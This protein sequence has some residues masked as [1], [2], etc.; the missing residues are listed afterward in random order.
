MFAATTTATTTHGDVDVADKPAIEAAVP[1][2]PEG[3]DGVVVRHAADYVFRWID[4]IDQGPPAKEAPGEEKFQ[5]DVVKVEIADHG[6]LKGRVHG[7][8]R[9]RFRNGDDVDEVD[10][11][12]HGEESDEETEAVEGGAA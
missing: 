11:D 10:R 8:L 9:G 3:E 4:A 12:F 7:P 5:P 2:A 1:A 6:D